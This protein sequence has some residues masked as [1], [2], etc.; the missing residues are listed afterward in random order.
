[1][2]SR[3]EIE[4]SGTVLEVPVVGLIVTD[5]PLPMLNVSTTM[6]LAVRLPLSTSSPNNTECGPAE[7]L[8]HA[9]SARRTFRHR[10]RTSATVC[11]VFLRPSDPARSAPGAGQPAPVASRPPLYTSVPLTHVHHRPPPS[12]AS[13]PPTST[14]VRQR[15]RYRTFEIGYILA[16]LGPEIGVRN[17][18]IRPRKK[19]RNSLRGYKLEKAEGTG[20][21]PATPFGAPHFQCGQI[22]VHHRPLCPISYAVAYF[23]RRPVSTNVHGLRLCLPSWLQIGYTHPRAVI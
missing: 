13:R 12:A 20:L 23:G 7:R 19:P 14:V 21:E 4:G 16:T 9:S 5:A 18:L 2:P 11:S 22:F 8:P 10:P 15:V 1:M 6:L 3:M 17:G